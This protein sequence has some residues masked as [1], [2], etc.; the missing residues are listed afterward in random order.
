MVPTNVLTK[1][2]ERL[3]AALAVLNGLL[4][5]V[6]MDALYTLLSS[7]GIWLIPAP[8][9]VAYGAFTAWRANALLRS[10]LRDS[11]EIFGRAVVEGAALLGISSVA[12]TFYLSLRLRSSP[13]AEVDW[14]TV[15]YAAFFY[16]AILSVVGA[17]V[18]ALLAA[19]D[20]VCVDLVRLPRDPDC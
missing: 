15:A 7:P 19:L 16:R 9:A 6:A 4:A 14:G 10:Y 17:L 5:V 3:A 11:T 1:R 20:L 13:W 12:Y 2:Q 18:A 8:I